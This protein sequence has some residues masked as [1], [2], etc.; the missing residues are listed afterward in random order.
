VL[1]T[2]LLAAA[3]A[4]FTYSLTY[5]LGVHSAAMSLSLSLLSLR[6]ARRS[7]PL[8]GA[9]SSSFSST[10]KT[11]VA[12]RDAVASSSTAK[13]GEKKGPK[14]PFVSK[15]D[16]MLK[17]AKRLQADSLKFPVPVH[18][19]DT[20]EILKENSY[21]K[22]DETVDVCIKLGLDPRKPEQ[23]VK[24]VAKLPF[25]TGKKVRVAVFASGADAS[26]ALEAGADI[27]GDS[28]LIARVQGGEVLFDT[29]IA[30]PEMMVQVSKIGKI[31][32]PRGLMPNPKLGTVTK[33]VAKAVK[34]A[35][36]GTVQFRVDK[37]GFVHAGIGKVS[38]PK[39]NLLENFRSFMMAISDCKPEGLKTKY[40]LGGRLAT[41]FLKSVP[42]ETSSIDPSSPRF[43]LKVEIKK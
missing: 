18:I 6:L 33:D 8:R 38:F 1:E 39:E 13:D 7:G 35:K 3:A 16:R 23:S 41:T 5:L 25:G 28:D 10:A 30:T 42:V 36:A 37:Q 34:S 15:E 29:A 4:R 2:S 9:V 12:V 11:D 17:K 22:F 21:A 20:M 31:L 32:G 14:K 26:A 19:L 27:V 40:I 24:G 43:M